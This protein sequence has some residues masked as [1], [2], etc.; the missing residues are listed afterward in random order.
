MPLDQDASSY[1]YLQLFQEESLRF[2]FQV[3]DVLRAPSFLTG[4]TSMCSIQPD[5][6]QN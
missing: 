2:L 5:F 3:V 1:T 6:C 4:E